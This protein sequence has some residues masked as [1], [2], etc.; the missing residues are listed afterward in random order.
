M[1]RTFKESADI[2]TENIAARLKELAHAVT[3][4]RDAVSR[5]FTMRIPAELDHDADLVLS[6]AARRLLAL[7]AIPDPA[8]AMERVRE[9]L[10]KGITAWQVRR[11]IEFRRLGLP[12]PDGEPEPPWVTAQ[13]E[14]LAA[15]TPAGKDVTK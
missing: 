15:L 13:R 3:Q 4:G 9:A 6:E 10:A 11:D 1:S 8:W 12:V 2:P 14:A 7:P 5:E